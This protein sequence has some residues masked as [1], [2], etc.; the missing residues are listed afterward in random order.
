MPYTEWQNS[1]FNDDGSNPMSCQ[2]CHM[3]KTT[4]R[5]SNR[6]MWLGTKEGFAKHHLV[7]ANTV[8]LTLLRDNA[9]ALDVN[10]SN[11][12]LGINRAR[13]MLHSAATVE[14]V[15]ASVSNGVLEARVRVENHSGHK[16]PTSYPSRRM[17]L[18]F[19][20]TGSNNNI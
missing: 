8:M 1:I 9:A 2:D 13:D 16:A 7:G 6:P 17:W 5:V 4:A 19:K 14:I 20:V 15:S 18:H 3:P 12:D 11:L 10:S